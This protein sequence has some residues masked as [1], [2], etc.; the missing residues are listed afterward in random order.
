[1][2]PTAGCGAR[3]GVYFGELAF[4]ED[5]RPAS[6]IPTDVARPARTRL[7]HDGGGLDERWRCDRVRLTASSVAGDYRPSGGGGSEGPGLIAG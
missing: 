3:Y 5:L 6:L 2:T 7:E 1:M 4:A